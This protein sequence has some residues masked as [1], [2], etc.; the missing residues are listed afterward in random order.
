VSTTKVRRLPT[1]PRPGPIGDCGFNIAAGLERFLGSPSF[2]PTFKVH[3][4][5]SRIG[6]EQLIN[7]Y[8]LGSVTPT[9]TIVLGDSEEKDYREQFCTMITQSHAARRNVVIVREGE[10]VVG[11]GRP[12]DDILLES[13]RDADLVLL[14]LAEPAENFVSYYENLQRRVRGLPTTAFVLAAEDISFGEVLL[15]RPSCADPC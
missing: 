14:G 9:N 1:T 7:A 3:W 15:E 10:I 12:F 11:E 4:A 13:S 6:A 5:L 8:G 2:R